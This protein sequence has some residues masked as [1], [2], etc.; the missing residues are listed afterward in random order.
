MT[1]RPIH[2]LSGRLSV[3][4]AIQ[5]F[6]GLGLVSVAVY[7]L[8]T[9]DLRER[10][11]ETLTHKRELV[12][13]LLSEAKLDQDVVNLKHKL[14]D[15]FLG[16]RDM[17]LT[18]I[19]SDGSALYDNTAVLAT[20]HSA[21]HINFRYPALA[22]AGG[23]ITARLVLSTASDDQFLHRLAATLLGAAMTG[24]LLVSFGSFVL[25]RI[26]LGPVHFLVDQTMRLEADNLRQRLD[27]S[28]QPLELQ[29]LIKQFNA[30]LERLC[31][32]YE[33]LEGFN[34][35]V[36][37]EL[38]TPLATLITSTEL[39][40]RRTHDPVASQ[41]LLG[42]N[43]E[44]LRRM[45]GIVNDMLFLSHANSGAEARREPLASLAALA[46]DVAEYH[47]AAIAEADLQ[48]SIEGDA[49]GDFDA[50]LLKRALS[51]LLGNATRYALPQ[52]TVRIRIDRPDNGSI[53]LAVINQGQE[54]A[55]ADLLRLF[56][57]FYRVDA[58]RPQAS[59]NHGLGLS[60]VAAIARMH[61]GHP[62]AL[63]GGGE[64]RIGFTV[65]AA[66]D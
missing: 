15:F 34:A 51:N 16:H 65:P 48:L 21:Q 54:I 29:P 36:A 18:L 26:G 53:S 19:R 61:R 28:G 9:I 12:E 8:T 39:A 17:A 46:R 11:I 66:A 59:V 20:A 50:S 52:S 5:T 47:D 62:F 35:D 30:L 49:S 3:W 60:I 31:R 1:A 38:R 32:A 58:A 43:L 55:E 33:Q 14:D 37:H 25:V 2:S 6:V 42:S 56:D 41:E 63:S 45:A 13:H 27:G 44:E 7:W 23:E 24:A 22:T 40:M 64:T 57:R 4:L 10:Q